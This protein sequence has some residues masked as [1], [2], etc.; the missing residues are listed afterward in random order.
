MID[1]RVVRAEI[2]V[3]EW[4]AGARF[5]CMLHVESEVLKHAMF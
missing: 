1:T 4:L 3:E 2:E 5:A